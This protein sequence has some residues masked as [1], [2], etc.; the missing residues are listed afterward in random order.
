MFLTPHTFLSGA[1]AVG[2]LTHLGTLQQPHGNK[3]T[4]LS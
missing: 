2:G 1:A 3:A 4:L